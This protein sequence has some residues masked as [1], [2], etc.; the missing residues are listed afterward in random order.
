[1]RANRRPARRPRRKAKKVAVRRRRVPRGVG[2]AMNQHATIIETYDTPQDVLANNLSIGLNTFALGL[3]PRAT[4]VSQFYKWYKAEYVEYIYTPYYN[5]F[6]GTA[7]SG[8]VPY[9][10]S[11]MNR[12]QDIATPAS[13]AITEQWLQSQGAKPRPFDRKIVIKYKPNWCSPGLIMERTNTAT[14]S[15]LNAV[16]IAGLKCNYGWLACPDNAGVVGVANTVQQPATAI[17]GTFPA[18]F[19]MGTNFP[20]GV[21]YNGHTDYLISGPANTP[22]EKVGNLVVRVKWVFKNPN[23][24]A[25]PV[26]AVEKPAEV[27]A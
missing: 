19:T 22:I 16:S 1:M 2:N 14:P 10:Y 24:Y 17:S 15:A 26:P 25:L 9:F 23:A 5:T 13:G 8:A 6:D 3:F 27:A 18:G 11:I 4:Q 21:C 7:S 20:Q 12:T